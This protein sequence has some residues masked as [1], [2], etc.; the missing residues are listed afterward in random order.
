LALDFSPDNKLLASVS[1]DQ[2]IRIWDVTAGKEIYRIDQ[3]TDQVTGIDFTSDGRFLVSSS[4]D[5]T[6][7]VW[8][9]P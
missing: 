1:S 6:I 5:G 2:T 7:R 9:L 8:G 4:F 3:H